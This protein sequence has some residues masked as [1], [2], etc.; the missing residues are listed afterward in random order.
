[1]PPADQIQIRDLTGGWNPSVDAYHAPLNVLLRADNLIWEHGGVPRIRPGVQKLNT[2]PYDGAIRSLFTTT[3]SG[4]RVRV[5]GTSTGAVYVGETLVG[6]F[7]G[8]G[9]FALGS[10]KGQVLMARGSVK[11]KSSY[12]T[13]RNW[14]VAADDAKSAPTVAASPGGVIEIADGVSSEGWTC[15]TSEGSPAYVV[16]HDGTAGGAIKLTPNASSHRG[17]VTMTFSSPQDFDD[18]GGGERGADTDLLEFYAKVEGFES[19]DEFQVQFDCNEDSAAVF[20]DDYYIAR[21]VAGDAKK[22]KLSADEATAGLGDETE[23]ER[24]RARRAVDEDTNVVT[25]ISGAES[26][27][28]FSLQR[29]KCERIGSTPNK[30]WS[31]I[32]AIRIVAYFNATGGALAMDDITMTGGADHQMTGKYK[33][34]YCYVY[35]SGEYEGKSGLSEISD[36]VEVRGGG[37]SVTVPASSDSQV[38]QTWIYIMGGALDQAYRAKVMN[39]NGGTATVGASEV[40]IAV[41]NITPENNSAPPD[42]AIAIVAPHMS[43]VWVLTT[44]K[45]W[46]SRRNNPDSFDATQAIDIGDATETP[47]WLALTPDQSLYVGTSKN[48]YRIGGKGLEYPDGTTDFSK[49]P[50]NVEPPIDS[51]V[52]QD[53][54][55]LHYMASDGWR[56]FAGSQTQRIVGSLDLLYR[57]L[58]RYGVPPVNLGSAH[59]RFRCAFYAGHLYC[60]SGE[61]VSGNDEYSTAL[62][63]LHAG[64]PL[65]YRHTYPFG[66]STLYREPDGKIL[67]GCTDGYVR[68]LGV[69]ETDDGEKIPVEFWTPVYDAGE[70]LRFK[71]PFDFEIQADTGATAYTIAYHLDAGDTADATNSFATNGLTVSRRRMDTVTPYRGIQLRVTGES[72]AF[73][74]TEFAFNFRFRPLPRL[75]VDTGYVDTGRNYTSWC[76]AVRIKARAKTTLTATCYFDDTAFGPYTITVDPD[77]VTHYRVPV[78]RSYKGRQPRVVLSAEGDVTADLTNAGQMRIDE[79]SAFPSGTDLTAAERLRFNTVG[80]GGGAVAAETQHSFECYWIEFQFHPT[81]GQTQASVV[82]ATIG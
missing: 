57:G 76:R 67:A 15:D 51:A 32:K 58:Q 38:N 66:I 23:F 29:G 44:T 47:Y 54:Y 5:K 52:A 7:N 55:V 34:L 35:S 4:H 72:T 74:L 49:E 8:S 65:R 6:M 18:Y 61:S 63:I 30:N 13:V 71:D 77:K 12:T 80:F 60:L 14:G 24:R 40:D 42:N 1:M 16:A 69:G 10:F 11:K 78:P 41:A 20:Q 75:Y 39:S 81:G 9:D 28:R 27:M 19:L 45:L 25:R 48:I 36:P 53:G 17:V 62:H 37:L 59:A 79:F 31:T 46:P 21:F 56:T 3:L 2:S 73:V 22:V 33:A 68:E 70:P 50:I 26:W 43:R 64:S 82:R